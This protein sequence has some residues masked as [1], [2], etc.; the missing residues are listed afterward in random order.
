MSIAVAAITAARIS[1]LGR[2]TVSTMGA[3]PETV[4]RS[5]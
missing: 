4:L 3:R 5:R 2:L 1:T